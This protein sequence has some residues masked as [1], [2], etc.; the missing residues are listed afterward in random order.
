MPESESAQSKE[1]GAARTRENQP[2]GRGLSGM[3][4]L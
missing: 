3:L 4:C 2:V 1:A